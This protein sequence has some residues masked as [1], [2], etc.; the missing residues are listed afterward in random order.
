MSILRKVIYPILIIALSVAGQA[1]MAVKRG[2]NE[3]TLSIPAANVTGNGNI[4]A[5]IQSSI[6]YGSDGFRFEPEIGG[7]IGIGGI[8]QFSGLMVPVGDKGLGPIEAHLQATVPGNDKL[9][10]VNVALLAD[11]FL[12]TSIDTISLTA[13][14]SKPDYHPHL[15]PSL[16]VDIDWLSRWKTLPLKSYLAFSFS[17]DPQL[18]HKYHQIGMLWG[19]EWKM[20]KHS[21]FVNG[22]L[23]LYKEKG[24]RL[25]NNKG[26][27]RYEQIYSWLEPGGRYR[28]LHRFSI[29]GGFRFTFF[30]KVKKH[31][32][33][34]PGLLG[35]SIKLEAPV[36]FRE[37]NTE[38]IRTLVFMEE[39]KEESQDALAKNIKEEKDYLKGFSFETGTMFEGK[40]SFEYKK[41]QNE[42]IKQRKAIQKKMAEIEAILH[43]IELEDNKSGENKDE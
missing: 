40:E 16:L 7:Q 26:D 30:Q 29:V 34:K 43:E 37:T 15:F 42:L 24:H 9:R 27:D 13:D 14:S 8:L 1:T 6:L 38:A 31:D 41:E 3:G 35:L 12:A 2:R 5:F 32:G 25:N 23:G 11:L 18:L 10:F 19:V 22:G 33:L 39:Q 20:Y 36:Y 17:D 4:T 28:F 21:L